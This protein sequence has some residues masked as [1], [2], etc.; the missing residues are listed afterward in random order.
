MRLI[1]ETNNLII[2]I[3]NLRLV[4]FT[5]PSPTPLGSSTEIGVERRLLRSIYSSTRSL[6]PPPPS[7]LNQQFKMT[8]PIKEE[9]AQKRT[10]I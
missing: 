8:E 9:N 5:S 1:I 4:N 2:N 10:R 3:Y 7:F 6:K